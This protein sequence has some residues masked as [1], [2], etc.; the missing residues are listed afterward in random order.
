[1]IKK[2]ISTIL[3]F[4]FLFLQLAC[5]GGRGM[6]YTS[7]NT[8]SQTLALEKNKKRK[9]ILLGLGF[10]A[11][12]GV[13][14]GTGVGLAISLS[15]NACTDDC[16]TLYVAGA[17]GAGIFLLTSLIGLGVGALLPVK[18]TDKPNNQTLQFQTG[19]E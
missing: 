13:A 9:N 7:Q 15:P 16:E 8:N 6:A 1:M 11:G 12:A 2:T 3:I 17:V 5:A 14:I 18:T 19:Q 10:G 4:S